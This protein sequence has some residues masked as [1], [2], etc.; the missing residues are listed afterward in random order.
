MAGLDTE[1]GSW[2]PNPTFYRATPDLRALSI[3]RTRNPGTLG[4]LDL[5]CQLASRIA[6]GV[7][8]APALFTV[9]P[10]MLLC[11]MLLCTT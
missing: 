6:E 3:P 9:R 8:Q 7:H 10:P 11:E 4:L 5:M 2:I 1:P